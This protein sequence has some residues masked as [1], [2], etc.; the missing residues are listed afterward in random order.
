MISDK[1]VMNRKDLEE[2]S[3]GLIL[4]YYPG[5]RMEGVRKT[6]NILSPDSLSLSRDLNPWSPEY[7]AGVLT[8]RPRRSLYAFFRNAVSV[9]HVQLNQCLEILA[10]MSHLFM[11]H[12]FKK[13]FP[14]WR[15]AINKKIV[16]ACCL[17]YT[18]P[19]HLIT[20]V[21][22]TLIWSDATVAS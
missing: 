5:N 4:R 1:W 7:K 15:R 12:V 3:R 20:Q 6:T 9:I 14:W 17:E 16:K 22:V 11:E 21:V 10:A 2:R 13:Q 8:T 19:S 18:V